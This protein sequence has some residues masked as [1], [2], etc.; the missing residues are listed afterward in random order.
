MV[1][2]ARVLTNHSSGRA[3]R[4]AEFR[5][6]VPQMT[7][8][9]KTQVASDVTRDGLGIELL[10]EAGDVVA[11]VFRS[12]SQQTVLVNTFSYDIPLEAIE[13]L[14]IGAKEALEPFQNGIALSK[15]I[16]AAPK[17]AGPPASVGAQ[18]INQ[19]DR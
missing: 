7:Y 17:L 9:Y 5:R 15:A 6:W 3:A 13:M 19:A 16:L 12:D 8:R 1:A 4:A 18:L 2:S 14:V 11:E 10:N